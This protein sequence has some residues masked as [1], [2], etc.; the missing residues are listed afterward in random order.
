MKG[1]IAAALLFATVQSGLLISID[2]NTELFD[3]KV[4]S[5]D[6]ENIVL[7]TKSGRVVRIPT[8]S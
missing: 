4:E 6:A 3:G 5:V 1:I 2:A 8:K 7:R